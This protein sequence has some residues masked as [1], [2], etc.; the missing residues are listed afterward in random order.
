MNRLGYVYLDLKLEQILYHCLGENTFEIYIGD[1]GSL[2]MSNYATSIASFPPPDSCNNTQAY[3]ADDLPMGEPA[4]VPG[5]LLDIKT[6][7]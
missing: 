4:L 1:L 6:G 7:F 2:V 3:G 5:Y